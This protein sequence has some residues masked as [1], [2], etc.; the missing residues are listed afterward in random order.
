MSV[1]LAGCVASLWGSFVLDDPVAIEQS[2]CVTG[3]L[4][5][6]RIF[7]SNFWC[8][9]GPLW[10]IQSWRPLPVLAWW[11]LHR[12]GGSPVAFHLLNLALHLGCTALVWCLGH[13]LKLGERAAGFGALLFACLAIHVDAVAMAVGAS[14]LWSALFVL[15]ALRAFLA[16]RW[17]FLGYAGLAILAKESG[18]LF[19][20]LA[21]THALVSREPRFGTSRGT[22]VALALTAGIT[23]AILAWRAEVIGAWTGTEIPAHVNPVVALGVGP[24]LTAAV[25][26]VGRYHRLTVAGGPLSADYAHAAIGTGDATD[27]LDFTIGLLAIVGWIGLGW[28]QRKSPAVVFLAAWVLGTCSFYSNLLFAL[29]AMFAERLFYLPSVAVAL[30]AGWLLSRG[31]DTSKVRP[32]LVIGGFG[33][34]V[35]AQTALSMLHTWQ[36]GSELRII[37]ATVEATPNN[38]RARMWLAIRKLEAGDPESAREHARVAS[39]IRPRWGAPVALEAAV[40][41]V[42]GKPQVAIEGFRDAMQLDPTDPE[43]ANLFIQFLLRYGHQEHARMVYAAHSKARGAPHPEVVQ[44]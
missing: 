35:V 5:L 20:P 12:F 14:E 32:S 28:W 10:R 36:Y 24:R 4:D 41:D 7:S 37:E 17:W 40:A 13:D 19:L 9:P 3:A 2:Q 18:V 39:S 42:E 6:E 11:G 38:A 29:P 23:F 33:A 25:A 31:L 15:L 44:P 22:I 27:W 1:A 30:A 21:I 43:V 26:I 8:E 16:G 34:F